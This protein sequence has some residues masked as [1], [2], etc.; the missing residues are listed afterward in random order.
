MR[1]PYE[2][3]SIH[4]AEYFPTRFIG[5]FYWKVTWKQYLTLS[6]YTYSKY[7]TMSKHQKLQVCVGDGREQPRENRKRP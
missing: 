3:R 4:K 2:S 6:I 7:A 5:K 1:L